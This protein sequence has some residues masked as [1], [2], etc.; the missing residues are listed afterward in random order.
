MSKHFKVPKAYRVI[1]GFLR[2]DENDEIGV[3]DITLDSKQSFFCVASEREGWEHVSVSLSDLS[4]LPTHNEM[5][6]IK[7][8]FWDDECYVIEFYP[9]SSEFVNDEPVLHLWHPVDST[10]PMPRNWLVGIGN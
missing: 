5:E 8:L 1:G 10:L 6:Q 3:F 2:S 9:P 7:T 4:R